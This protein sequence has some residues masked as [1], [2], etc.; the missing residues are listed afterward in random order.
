M[1]DLKNKDLTINELLDVVES[2]EDVETLRLVKDHPSCSEDLFEQI[3]SK[4]YPKKVTA[5]LNKDFKILNIRSDQGI[6]EEVESELSSDAKEEAKVLVS[7]DIESIDL[8]GVRVRGNYYE[9]SMGEGPIEGH[10]F[11]LKRQG[12]WSFKPLVL[13]TI[14]SVLSTPAFAGDRHAQQ[15]EELRRAGFLVQEEKKDQ[16]STVQKPSEPKSRLEQQAEDL[17]RAGFDVKIKK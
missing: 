3:C 6:V 16:G 14:L 15:M 1:I 4:I 10:D 17:R 12:N 2:T 8:V 13:A 5:S 11:S 9:F 7:F